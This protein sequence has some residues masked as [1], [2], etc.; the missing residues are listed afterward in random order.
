MLTRCLHCLAPISPGAE[1]LTP[2]LTG[3]HGEVLD[4]SWHMYGCA[5]ADPLHLELADALDSCGP[6]ALRRTRELYTAIRERTVERLGTRAPDF[7]RQCIIV[8]RDFN[9]PRVTLRG[10]GLAWGVPTKRGVG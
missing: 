6:E 8:R 10:R 5:E 7:L 4:L 3:S 1:V 2:R 9:D